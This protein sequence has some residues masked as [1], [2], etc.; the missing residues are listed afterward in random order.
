MFKKISQNVVQYRL[1]LVN[2]NRVKVGRFSAFQQSHTACFFY[3]LVP[4]FFFFFA[5][6]FSDVV[7]PGII[8]PRQSAL[9]WGI[10]LTSV[11]WTILYSRVLKADEGLVD[12]TFKH[13]LPLLFTNLGRV[14]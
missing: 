5:C 6:V 13:P 9:R 12:C 4:G 14:A 10:L 7:L 11:L 8:T 1:R 2:F 3:L